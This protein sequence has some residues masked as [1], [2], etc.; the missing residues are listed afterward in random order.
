MQSLRRQPVTEFS[1][2]SIAAFRTLLSLTGAAENTLRAYCSDLNLFLAESGMTSIPVE[3]YEELAM[4]WLQMTRQRSNPPAPKTIARRITSL[5]TWARE[6]AGASVLHGYRG[7]ETTPGAPH[8][9]PEG[10]PGVLRMIDAARREQHRALVALCGLQGCRIGEAIALRHTNFDL[11][12]MVLQ[13]PG[14]G[15]KTRYVPLSEKAWDF[16]ARSCVDSMVNGT[17]LITTHERAARK[18]IT[19]L[20]ARA[21]LSRRVASHD[22]RATFATAIYDKTGDMVVTQRLLGHSNLSTTQIYVGIEW[23]KMLQ[24]V[25]SLI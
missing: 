16:M 9:I 20:G 21:K 6:M 4:T 7:P 17:T 14:K 24:A 1:T 2:D 18:V 23:K 25:D 19:N 13:I 22:L 11:E 8:P 3:E 15:S 12:K 10:I 5:R